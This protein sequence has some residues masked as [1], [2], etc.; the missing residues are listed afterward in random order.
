MGAGSVKSVADRKVNVVVKRQDGPLQGFLHFNCCDS[1]A[2]LQ[3]LGP[4]GLK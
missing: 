1:D 4:I 2:A 3:V